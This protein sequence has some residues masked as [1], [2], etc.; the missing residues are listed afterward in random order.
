QVH[1]AKAVVAAAGETPEADA[2]V[3]AEKNTGLA[4]VTAD[5]APVLFASTKDKIVG[6]AHAGWKG[7]LNGILEATVSEMEKLGAARGDIH[8]AIGPCIG[9]ASYEV[10]EGFKEPFLMQAP[11]NIRF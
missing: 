6:A 3:T 11:D 10:S 8:A 2:H 5:C 4:I 1:S 9:P 7:A